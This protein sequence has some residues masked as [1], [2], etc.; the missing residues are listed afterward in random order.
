MP[1]PP[2]SLPKS[3]RPTRPPAAPGYAAGDVAF[4]AALAAASL[5]AADA[6]GRRDASA[7]FAGAPGE[8]SVRGEFDRAAY[9]FFRPGERIPLDDKGAQAACLASYDTFAVVRSV[10]DIMA[11]FTARGADVNHPSPRVQA[12][13]RAWWK[14][15]GGRDACG[16]MATALFLAGACP[17]R[18]RWHALP[19]A[20]MDALKAADP[21]GSRPTRGAKIPVAYALLDPLLVEEL[22]GPAAREAGRPVRYG[23]RVAV[24]PPSPAAVRFAP[25]LDYRPAVTDSFRELAP[26]DHAVLHYKKPDYRAWARPMLYP[27]LDDLHML[28]KLRQADRAALD[29]VISHVRLWKLGSLDHKIV[30]GP[31]SF[32]RLQSLLLAPSSG[33]VLDLIW[34]PDI[35]LVETTAEAHKFL[36][37]EKYG[38]TVAAVYQGLGV[39]PALTGAG[40]DSGFT[41]NFVSLKVMLERLEYCRQ[42][43]VA[44][45]EAE[46]ALVQAA[47]GF[48]L[49][50]TLAFE[51]P[52]LSDDTAEKKLLIDLA[53]RDVISAELLVE[54][55]GGDPEMEAARVRREWRARAGGRLPPKAGP[56]H[57]DSRVEGDVK[58]AMLLDGRLAPSAAGLDIPDPDE[59]PPAGDP[60]APPGAPA[61]PAAPARGPGRPPGAKDSVR[62]QKRT[63]GPTQSVGAGDLARAAAWAA[64]AQAAVLELARDPYLRAAGRA[65]VRALTAAEAEAF[66]A[67]QFAALVALPPLEPV[68]AE[69]LAA[70]L[71]DLREPPPA[72]AALLAAAL[73]ASPRPTAEDRRRAAAGAAAALSL[74]AV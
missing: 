47:F 67:M 3:L 28:T 33:G 20:T 39:P 34:G 59:L 54:R 43:L 51:T 10:V 52:S 15:A 37:Q 60:A 7:P 44:F 11:D 56:F 48:R 30:P 16:R 35:E 13:G 64:G 71:A 42:V 65:S 9:D 74:T 58:K 6:G 22:D 14:K 24:A 5:A 72:A 73:A 38:P 31:D 36:G 40:G 8:P 1:R 23:T 57:G 29:G 66:E 55:F 70:V 17:V 2:H 62:R 46:L 69:S 41:N 50:F 61:A 25:G 21:A 19:D 53:D 63:D 49:P 27:M 68:T 26:A 18:R 4:A 12:I 32:D 45:W